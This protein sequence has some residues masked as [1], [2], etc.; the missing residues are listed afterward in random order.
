MNNR[1]IRLFLLH[2]AAC[3]LIAVLSSCSDS[4]SVDGAEVFK[5]EGCITCHTF[6]G[7]GGV[8]GP[9]LTYVTKNRSD[10]WIKDQIRNSKANNPDSRMPE[11]KHL[12]GGEVN[13]IVRYLK[14]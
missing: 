5:R 10:S 11:Y 13:A 9:D 3:L 4:G 8:V 7:Q 14:S 6:K 1:S 2:G 12:S